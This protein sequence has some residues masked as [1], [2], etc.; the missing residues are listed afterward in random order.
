MK[1]T[2]PTGEYDND[3]LTMRHKFLP[4]DS[5]ARNKLQLSIISST[6]VR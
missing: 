2:L 3:E 4:G 1:L 5:L 6:H